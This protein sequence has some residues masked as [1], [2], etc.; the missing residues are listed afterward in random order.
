MEYN[1]SFPKHFHGIQSGY[2]P[3]LFRNH[4][5][6]PSLIRSPLLSLTPSPG[7]PPI[8]SPGLLMPRSPARSFTGHRR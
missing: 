8:R 4:S 1:Q 6:H 3:L 7:V 5:T 2:D